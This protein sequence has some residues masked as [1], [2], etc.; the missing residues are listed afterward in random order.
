[1][2]LLKFNLQFF[3]GE[4]T[5]QATPKKRKDAREK[6]QVV[7][8][9]DINTAVI[10]LAVFIVMNA[11]KRYFVDELIGIFNI[12]FA[13]FEAPRLDFGVQDAMS[14]GT[15]TL[16]G[17]AKISLPLLSV[18]MLT[19][20]VLSYMQVGFLFTVEPLKP[21]LNKINPLSGFKRMFSMKSVIEM[22]KSILK[23]I[24]ILLISYLFVISRMD[25]IMHS[26]TL[27]LSQG[28]GVMWDITMGIIIRCGIF[29]FAV[30][31]F[32]FIYKRWENEKELRMSKQ[33]IKDEYKQME[34]DPLVKSKI[35]ERQRQMAMSRM[36]QEVPKADVIITNP[37]H[38]AVAL[39]YNRDEGVAPKVTAKGRDLVAQNI[40]K[41]AAENK[42][43]I[44][45]NKPLARALYAAVEID[46][47][48]PADL[49]EAVADV[50]AYV[51]Q[52][53][54]RRIE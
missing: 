36:M 50:L 51:Y 35:K 8:S 38:Y 13:M 12:T 31:L 54:R 1:M 47:Y 29:L 20:L 24:G 15:Q 40:K 37:S 26:M 22:I 30:A 3:Q 34:G 41:V 32:D 48:I 43:P 39:L 46:H 44:V 45:E 19:G 10:L 28:I 11:F 23:A 17:F 4:K 27:E 21:Q 33:E 52:L 6:G 18:S 5:E 2:P 49:F 25:F 7:Q 9:R 16:L 42:V 53:N 14:L